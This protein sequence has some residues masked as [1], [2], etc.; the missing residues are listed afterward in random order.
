MFALFEKILA[1]ILE[2]L[3]DSPNDGHPATQRA[4]T[5]KKILGFAAIIFILLAGVGYTVLESKLNDKTAVYKVTDS[6]QK[7]TIADL[8]RAN[9]TL[10]EERTRLAAESKGLS[11]MLRTERNRTAALE[12]A[13][14][15]KE[16]ELE[17]SQTLSDNRLAL[18]A[19][20]QRE[21][22]FAENQ[23]NDYDK[24]TRLIWDEL[25]TLGNEDSK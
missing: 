16:K 5:N 22:D 8:Q 18:I 17:D 11:D 21:L 3:K 25:T 24:G 7:K 4:A 2:A 15:A 13:L 20:Q 6:Q 1:F 23:L 10:K 14:T 19:K 12:R 9:S